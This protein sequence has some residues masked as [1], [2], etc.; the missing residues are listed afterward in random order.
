MG[1]ISFNFPVW[2]WLAAAAI[3]A[4]CAAQPRVEQKSSQSRSVGL[5]RVVRIPTTNDVEKI[6]SGPDDAGRLTVSLGRQDELPEGP[7]GFDV[8]EDGSFLLTDPLRKRIAV[9][10]R[11]GKYLSEWQVGFAAD[12]VTIVSDNRVQVREAKSGELHLFDL[13]G[14]PAG[15]NPSPAEA[16]EARLTGDGSG[17][18]NWRP[19]SGLPGGPMEV[20]FEQAG[21]RLLSLEGI[22]LEPP[23]D[24]YVAVESTA[25]GDAVDLYKIV[26][27]YSPD[28][29]VIRETT[30]LPLDYV[31]RPTDEI[32]VRK[33]VIYQLMTTRPEVQINVWDT[34]S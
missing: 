24:A 30:A 16:A 9:F 10:D 3:V 17:I 32:R 20:K 19:S 23:G 11:N 29:R 6:A 34:N 2:C 33:G 4:G 8:T 27:R 5:T 26:R 31:V 28:G 12:S 13:Q 15:G 25:G 14:K 22:A 7:D 18:V 1:R 21:M